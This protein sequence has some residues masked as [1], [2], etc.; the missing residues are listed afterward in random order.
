MSKVKL[1]IAEGYGSQG[2]PRIGGTER[3][4]DLNIKVPDTHD[5]MGV[6][7]TEFDK[8]HDGSVRASDDLNP[9]IRYERINDLV[10][11]LLT[12]IDATFP[13]LEQRKA[14]KTLFRD[15]AWDWY[16]GQSDQ[17]TEPW[18]L[19]KFPNYKKAFEE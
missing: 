9:V 18:R 1:I 16:R 17:L 14:M 3:V 10:G 7:R 11:R 13:D 8:D 19:D 12:V 6:I 5:I 2:L 4:L 15:V